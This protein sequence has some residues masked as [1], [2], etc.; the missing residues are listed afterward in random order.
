MNRMKNMNEPVLDRYEQA[1]EKSLEK[2]KYI[3][4]KNLRSSKKVFEEAV[5]NFKDLQKTKRVTLR[6][7]KEDLLKVKARAKRIRIPYQRLLRALI[8]QYAEGRTDIGI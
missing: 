6:V 4:V 5:K 2:G 1:I 3:S 8:H 7:N